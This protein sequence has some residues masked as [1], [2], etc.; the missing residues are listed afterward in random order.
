[1]LVGT[2]DQTFDSEQLSGAGSRLELNRWLA[3]D[4]YGMVD[5]RG[6]S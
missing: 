2:L 3:A 1:M 4:A 5:A 6:R